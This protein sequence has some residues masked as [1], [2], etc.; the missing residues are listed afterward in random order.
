MPLRELKP[1]HQHRDMARAL[2][3]VYKFDIA[4]D[5]GAHR[6]IVARYLATR[7]DLVV[8][9]EP[10]VY[11]TC[12]TLPNAKVIRKAVGDKPGR[13]ALEHGRKNT[14]QRHI[15]EGDTVDVVTID[16]LN[17]RPDFIKLDV[18][19]YEYLA[20]LG[21]ERTIR[22]YRPVVLFEENGLNR[23]YGIDDLASCR[24]LE[25]WGM[26]CFDVWNSI[27]GERDREFL[28]GW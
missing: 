5:C 14:G 10:S 6:G 27:A 1:D 24:L 25:S 7:F 17:V 8:C 3:H 19:G 2:K 22:E 9:V 16:S 15:V 18:E 26:R 23:R 11:A 13:A 12:I 28:Y 4:L 21:A 20:L